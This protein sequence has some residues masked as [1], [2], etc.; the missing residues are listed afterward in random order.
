METIWPLILGQQITCSLA[1]AIHPGISYKGF[2]RKYK[3]RGNPEE[4][5]KEYI[6]YNSYGAAHCE[7]GKLVF[8]CSSEED[9]TINKACG[10]TY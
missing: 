3:M 7:E 10:T 4:F 6:F 5:L 1:G 9:M 2:K 8:L